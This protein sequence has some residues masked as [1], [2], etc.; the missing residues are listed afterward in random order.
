MKLITI[1]CSECGAV[2]S[3]DTRFQ[4]DRERAIAQHKEWHRNLNKRLSVAEKTGIQG[5]LRTAVYG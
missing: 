2:L 4:E 5:D 1:R 3:T